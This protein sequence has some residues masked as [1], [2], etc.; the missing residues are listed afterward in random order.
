MP[1]KRT[2]VSRNSRRVSAR[3]VSLFREALELQNVYDAHGEGEDCELCATC[4]K[5]RAASRALWLELRMRPWD[6]N[7][8]AAIGEPHDRASSGYLL[9]WERAVELRAELMEAIHAN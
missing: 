1:S 2:R 5:W 4:T 7:P 3:A 8:L 9:V 6:V